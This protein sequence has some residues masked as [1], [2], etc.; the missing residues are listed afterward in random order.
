MKS[1]IVRLRLWIL[2][3]LVC[4][5]LG[6]GIAYWKFA[7]SSSTIGETVI[8]PPATNTGERDI[9]KEP[10]QYSADELPARKIPNS[11]G[12]SGRSNPADEKSILDG[13]KQGVYREALEL[14]VEWMSPAEL[15]PLIAGFSG[16]DE[17]QLWEMEDPHAFGKVL[18]DLRWRIAR[19]RLLCRRLPRCCLQTPPAITVLRHPFILFPGRRAEF[20]RILIFRLAT[21]MR[22]SWCVGVVPVLCVTTCSVIILL[23]NGQARIMFGFRPNSPSR[24]FIM[25][26][27]GRRMKIRLCFQAGVMR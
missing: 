6:Y 3:G 25:C 21:R 11:A 22:V 14:I 19:L 5:F 8:R 2:T 26:I 23:T 1:G 15:L 20:T 4:F 27:Y 10:G 13:V 16:M 17:E 12:P 24:E 18:A 7:G 9:L